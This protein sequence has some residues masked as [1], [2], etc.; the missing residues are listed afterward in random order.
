MAGISNIEYAFSVYLKVFTE[1]NIPL[2]RLSQMLSYNPAQRLGLKTRASCGRAIRRTSPLAVEEEGE[3]DA[4]A[5][6]SL[7]QHA[8]PRK[9]VQGQVLKT[10][11]EGETRY[12]YG[13]AIS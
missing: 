10:I 7:A 11:V 4:Y 3:I 12:E 8:L 13:Q 9:S 5:M 6:I 2:T 1:H